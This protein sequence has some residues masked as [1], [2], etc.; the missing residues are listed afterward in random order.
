MSRLLTNVYDVNRKII[1]DFTPEELYSLYL[2]SNEARQFLNYPST[3]KMIQ[4]KFLLLGDSF[5]S[6]YNDYN[7]KKS[8]YLE[9]YLYDLLSSGYYDV[10]SP[11]I[12]N[13]VSPFTIKL[14]AGEVFG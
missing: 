1:Q 8:Q 9:D 13:L 7:T 12:I 3:I 10:Y 14:F 2:S 4:N 6:L 5:L 11:F